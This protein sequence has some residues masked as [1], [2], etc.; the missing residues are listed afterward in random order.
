[1]T[2]A[3]GPMKRCDGWGTESGDT[4][5]GVPSISQL[6][7]NKGDEL[8]LIFS[9]DSGHYSPLHIQTLSHASK[10]VSHFIAQSWKP[11][12]GHDFEYKPDLL[13]PKL[14]PTFHGLC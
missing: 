13:E 7:T 4:S 5:I 11:N 1:M 2:T 6:A 8:K 10:S 14:H 12:H 9:T 3:F